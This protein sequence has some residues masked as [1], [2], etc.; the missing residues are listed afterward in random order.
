MIGH[1][2]GDD[3]VR[4]EDCDVDCS[5]EVVV[6]VVIAVSLA[7]LSFFICKSFKRFG[8]G[9]VCCGGSDGVMSCCSG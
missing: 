9:L 7:S 2:L 5:G 6:V 4:M 3:A 8:F 1:D